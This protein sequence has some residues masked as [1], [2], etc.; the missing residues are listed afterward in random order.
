MW[1]TLSRLDEMAR[2]WLSVSCAQSE[3]PEETTYVGTKGY[4]RIMTPAH[5]ST[6]VVVTKVR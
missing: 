4:I 2:V 1:R 3:T 5:C 6:K